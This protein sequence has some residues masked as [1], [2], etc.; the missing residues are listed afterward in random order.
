MKLCQGRDGATYYVVDGG[1]DELDVT[2]MLGFGTVEGASLVVRYDFTGMILTADS[3]TTT[4][5][6][7][8]ITGTTGMPPSSTLRQGG[9]AKDDYVVFLVTGFEGAV[10]D[11][12]MLT[13]ALENVAI[14]AGG[15]SIAMHVSD[16]LSIPAENMASYSGAVNMASALKPVKMR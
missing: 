13:L 6:A 5:P 8:T 9:K 15:G 16:D 10:A 4:P 12:V 3:V 7:L 1:G 11:T 2:A 14:S